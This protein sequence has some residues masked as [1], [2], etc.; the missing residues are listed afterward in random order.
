MMT[1]RAKMLMNNGHDWYVV[2]LMD[3]TNELRHKTALSSI[4]ECG[5]DP[6]EFGFESVERCW[7]GE[8]L[9]TDA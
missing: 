1:L 3:G 4:L 9:S 7:N 2:T 8:D 5:A 6:A